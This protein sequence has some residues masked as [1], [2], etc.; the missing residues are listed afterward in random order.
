MGEWPF[1]GAPHPSK[2]RPRHIVV[3]A[4][5]CDWRFLA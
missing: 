4:C 3:R 2:R 5:V 1:L